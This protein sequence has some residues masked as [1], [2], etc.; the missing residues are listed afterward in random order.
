VK[1]GVWKATFTILT[2]AQA[3]LTETAYFDCRAVKGPGLAIFIR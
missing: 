2:D 1:T 3:K